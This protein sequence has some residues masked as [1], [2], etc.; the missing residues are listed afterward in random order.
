MMR[1]NSVNYIDPY[2]C[3]ENQTRSRPSL[4]LPIGNLMS[5][6]EEFITTIKE[7]DTC[8]EVYDRDFFTAVN[9]QHSLAVSISTV[10]NVT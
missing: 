5:C 3:K 9:V 6:E 4:D 8:G 10:G 2:V 7:C 1:K